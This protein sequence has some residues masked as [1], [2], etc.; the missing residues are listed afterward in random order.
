MNDALELWLIRHGETTYSA[1]KRVAGWSD[2]PLTENGR[3]QA[4]AL[5]SVIDGQ[6]FVGVWSSDLDRAIESA[7]LAW[8]EPR[9]DSRLREC[10]FGSLE[11]CTY[12]Q[13]DT[14]YGEVFHRFRGFEV[15]GGESHGEFRDRVLSFVD[16]LIPGRHILFVHGGVIR[17]LTQDLGVDRFV[18][19]GS[20][21]GLDWN[22]DQVM[23][24]HEPGN[25]R[26]G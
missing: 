19:T 11:G 4:R 18:A 14:V 17:V 1:E 7:R 2:P 22:G 16:G 3:R 26:S 23:F 6:E 25:T 15:P 8:G 9:A 10:H 24:L 12:E 21:V 5:R 20:L 13:A